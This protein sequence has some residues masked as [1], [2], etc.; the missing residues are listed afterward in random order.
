M[1]RRFCTRAP[2]VPLPHTIVCRPAHRY[3]RLTTPPGARS[4]AT[5]AP[6]PAD[7]GGPSDKGSAQS[8]GSGGPASVRPCVCAPLVWLDGSSDAISERQNHARFVLQ[9]YT[10]CTWIHAYICDAHLPPHVPPRTSLVTPAHPSLSMR[11]PTHMSACMSLHMPTSQGLSVLGA[12]WL[13]MLIAG[14]LCAG[15]GFAAYRHLEKEREKRGTPDSLVI[16]TTS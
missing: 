3:A 13:N 4:L 7:S 16:D 10:C 8:K 1:L 9:M 15:V 12:G 5:E 14:T 11:M 2:L 6:G